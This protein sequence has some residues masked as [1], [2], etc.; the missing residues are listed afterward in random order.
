MALLLIRVNVKKYTSPKCY[1]EQGARYRGRL[2]GCITEL[3]TRSLRRS[4][5]LDI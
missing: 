3:A 5:G 4:G 2:K 1:V